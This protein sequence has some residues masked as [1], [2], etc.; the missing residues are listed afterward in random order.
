MMIGQE[1]SDE[2]REAKRAVLQKLLRV[3]QREMAAGDGNKPLEDGAVQDAMA[4]EGTVLEEGGDGLEG[5]GEDLDLS[6]SDDAGEEDPMRA[7]IVAFMQEGHRLPSP[8][9]GSKVVI[10]SGG[11]PK[12]AVRN[13][14]PADEAVKASKG[15]RKKG[16]MY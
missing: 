7:E 6:S 10:G 3:M 1:M 15:R 2:A 14:P 16:R 4:E 12:G 8:G 11:R 5:P 13:P 9:K